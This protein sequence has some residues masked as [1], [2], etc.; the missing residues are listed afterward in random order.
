MLGG[1]SAFELADVRSVEVVDEGGLLITRCRIAD[2]DGVERTFD[3]PGGARGTTS[4]SPR[5]ARGCTSTAARRG[6]AGSVGATMPE[7]ALVR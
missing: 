5:P 3:V 7:T 2:E 1:A 4:A 6:A